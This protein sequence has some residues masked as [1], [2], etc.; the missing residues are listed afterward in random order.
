MNPFTI[1]EDYP[2][3]QAVFD[4]R[5]NTEKACRDYFFKLRWPD[6]LICIRYGGKRHWKSSRE[7]YICYRCETQK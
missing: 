5:F 7:L 4:A 2:M 3:N 1:T 6:G